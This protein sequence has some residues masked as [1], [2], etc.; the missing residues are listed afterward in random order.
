MRRRVG[1]SILFILV[2][3]TGFAVW[4]GYTSYH[5]YQ[6]A[7]VAI[8]A[9]T[10]PSEQ[11]EA[12]EEFGGYNSRMYG[13]IL[14][15]TL[16][17]HVWVMGREGL[18]HYK[19]DIYTIY[20]TFDGCSPEILSRLNSGEAGAIERSI[21]TKMPE[22]RERVVIGDYVR[23]YPTREEHLNESAGTVGNLREIYGYNFW[24]F[25]RWGMEE[26]CQAR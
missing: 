15:G 18:R 24:L 16:P 7:T 5:N 25:M 8:E 11:S 3:I 21:T 10:D 17:G 9:I 19:T 12:W 20:S 2:I 14:L 26:R 1:L 6:R 22:W 13:G 4:Q 23:A